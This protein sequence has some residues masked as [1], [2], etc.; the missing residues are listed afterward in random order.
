M[1][2]RVNV[3]TATV[4]RPSWDDVW[5]QTATTVGQRSL[6]D[7][8]KVGAV[9][10]T[11]DNRVQAASFNG[12]ADRIDVQGK[13]CTHWCER[14]ATGDLSGDYSRCPAIHAEQN[15]LLRADYSQI[16][17]GTLYCTHAVCINCSKIVMGSG[18]A[19]VVYRI[20]E[21]DAYRNPGVVIDQMVASGI[22]VVGW[23][24]S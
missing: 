19:R 21:S 24:P 18:L 3:V 16:Q 17:G 5:M 11:K 22:E 14:M 2:R 7:R 8:A 9:V 10:V 23:R 13:T 1:A 15:A 4:G 20:N 6:C 12:A